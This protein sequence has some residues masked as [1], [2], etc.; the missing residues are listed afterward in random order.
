MIPEFMLEILGVAQRRVE[1]THNGD[2]SLSLSCALLS[3]LNLQKR[4]HHLVNVSSILGE[5]ESTT[6][7]VIIISHCA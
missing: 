7:K 2:D 5:V 6:C 1:I 3:I 4:V